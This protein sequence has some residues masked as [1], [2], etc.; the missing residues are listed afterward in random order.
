MSLALNLDIQIPN[1][2]E[3]EM[4]F[5]RYIQNFVTI[6]GGITF[7]T[8]SMISV[9]AAL[10]KQVIKMDGV[11]NK[12]FT[13]VGT[14]LLFSITTLAITGFSPTEYQIYLYTCYHAGIISGSFFVMLKQEYDSENVYSF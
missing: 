13:V 1:E 5:G 9:L 3:S 2:P 4:D 10:S 14:F 8:I 12:I 6:N 7:L 11:T